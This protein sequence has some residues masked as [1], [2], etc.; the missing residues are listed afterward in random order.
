MAKLWQKDYSLDSLIESFTVGRDYLLDMELLPADCTASLAHASMLATVGLLS[1]SELSSLSRGIRSILD[2]YGSG[3]YRIEKSDEDGHTALENRLVALCGEAGKK[4]HTGRSR[5]DQVITALRLY[6]RAFLSEAVLA[7][8][9]TVDALLKLAR[10]HEKTPM[11]G[12]THMQIAMPSSVGLWAAAYAEELL[13]ALRQ[14]LSIDAVLDQSPLGSAASYGVPLPLDRELTAEL[15]GFSGVQNNV[16]YVN[17]SRGKFESYLLDACEQIGLTLSKMAQDL[18]LFSLPE[19]GYFSLPRELCS[20]SSIMPQKKNPDGL[21]L[22]R[23]K[24]ATLSSYASQVKGILRSLPSGYNRDFQETKEPFLRGA[25]LCIQMLRVSTLTISKLEV[26]KEALKRGF[27]PEIYATDVALEM[28]ARGKSFRDAYREVGTA[29]EQVKDRDPGESLK[30]RSS[31]GSPGNLNLSFAA[32]RAAEIASHARA[33]GE[34]LAASA[35][36]LVGREV[37]LF[38]PLP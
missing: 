12:R 5:N 26:N 6:S 33:L 2:E 15:M 19:F 23:A 25:R 28:A 31:T 16:L 35:S 9:D 8:I 3:E 1:D 20:G 30:Q 27:T 22:M 11:P 38:P 18:I 17:N 14:L 10:E 37:P 7:G 34:S 21:E 13:D 24:S 29:L 36:D 32:T 4:I